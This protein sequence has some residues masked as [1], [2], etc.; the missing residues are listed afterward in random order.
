M[1]GNIC[2]VHKDDDLVCGIAVHL[3]RQLLV[4]EILDLK[5]KLA[6]LLADD[7]EK[8][9]AELMADKAKLANAN[10]ELR[11]RLGLP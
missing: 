10:E 1:S 8:I 6:Q 11:R 7:K 5:L 4:D 3:E 9:I 2:P